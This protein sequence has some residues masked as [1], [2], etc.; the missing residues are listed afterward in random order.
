MPPFMRTA[1][2]NLHLV[3]SLCLRCGT[4]VGTSADPDALHAAESN[5][6]CALKRLAATVLRNSKG[7]AMVRWRFLSTKASKTA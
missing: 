1:F 2:S 7:R 5:H 6:A 4:T 3:E